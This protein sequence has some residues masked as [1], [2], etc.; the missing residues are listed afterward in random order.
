MECCI[1]FK[2]TK[3]KDIRQLPCHSSRIICIQCLRKYATNK[4]N[5]NCPRCGDKILCP[6]LGLD[7]FKVK[8]IFGILQEN[9]REEIS[10][11]GQELKF[12]ERSANDTFGQT[13]GNLKKEIAEEQNNL[14]QNIEEYLSEKTNNLDVLLKILNN[15]IESEEADEETL[16]RQE[17]DLNNI[18]DVLESLSNEYLKFDSNINDF[19][20]LCLALYGYEKPINQY[21]KFIKDIKLTFAHYPYFYIFCS[22]RRYH[23]LDKDNMTT[24]HCINFIDIAEDDRNNFYFLV[25]ENDYKIFKMKKTSN[26][27]KDV[28]VTHGDVQRRHSKTL[29]FLDK[30][31]FIVFDPSAKVFNIFENL[32]QNSKVYKKFKIKEFIY[33]ILEEEIM[34]CRMDDITTH[35]NWKT[36]QQTIFK[37]CSIQITKKEEIFQRENILK[38]IKTGKIFTKSSKYIFLLDCETKNATRIPSSNLK[39][40]EDADNYMTCKDEIQF[41]FYNA[42]GI[43]RSI[44]YD[45]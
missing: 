12:S 9:L 41:L 32:L 38:E 11:S 27:F 8:N 36:Q 29:L 1:C 20:N 44:T 35:S 6:K 45:F 34:Y 7:E 22:N 2:P 31:N 21:E 23:I 17:E 14:K 43:A 13:I 5:F 30:R 15:N 3:T 25:R 16:S 19:N 4:T 42:S 28:N 26:S 39:Y 10:I 33:F 40:I 37:K 24:H 18:Q